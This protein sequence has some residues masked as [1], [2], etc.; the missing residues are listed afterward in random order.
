MQN[1]LSV[2]AELK[3]DGTVRLCKNLP[4]GGKSVKVIPFTDFAKAI[5]P[6]NNS[7]SVD[8][9]VLPFNTKEF[10]IRG[11][12]VIIVQEFP[13]QLIPRFVYYGNSY[14]NIMS[15]IAIWISILRKNTDSTYRVI[16]QAIYSSEMPVLSEDQKLK[17]WPLP[18]YTID[19]GVCWGSDPFGTVL[20]QCNLANLSSVNNSYLNANFNDD[21]GYQLRGSLDDYLNS[22]KANTPSEAKPFDVSKLRDSDYTYR[23]AVDNLIQRVL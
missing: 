3:G 22:V 4:S 1:D 23:Q 5:Q 13:S 18:N 15:P 14:E 6:P 20:G 9:G 19:Y 11:N 7:I 10:L 17:Q 16:K 2:V 12:A 8:S 21:L